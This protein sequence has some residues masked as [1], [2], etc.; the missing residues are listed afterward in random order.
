[1]DYPETT[2]P[3][4]VTR[5]AQR[6]IDLGQLAWTRKGL[7]I[8]TLLLGVAGGYFYFRSQDPIYQSQATVQIVEPFTKNLP[9]SGVDAFSDRN[10]L[11]N[12]IVVMRSEHV[13][14]HA[15]ELGSLH[16]LPQFAGMPS[17]AIAAYLSGTRDLTVTPAIA[18]NGANVFNVSFKS[19]DASGAQRIVQAVIDA[20]ARYLRDQQTNVGEETLSLIQEARGEVLSKLE[21][22]EAE[23]DKFA[24]TSA[25]VYRDGKITSIHR[26]HAESYLL[27]KQRLMIDRDKI[28]SRYDAA[29]RGFKAGVPV[30]SLLLAMGSGSD[31]ALKEVEM[32]RAN[33]ASINRTQLLAQMRQETESRAERMRETMLM[34]LELQARQFAD[35]FGSGHPSVRSIEDNIKTVTELI[36]K[37]A[38]GEEE[39]KQKWQAAIAEAEAQANSETGEA[40][41]P[42]ERLAARLKNQLYFTLQAMQ[43]ELRALEDQLQVVATAYDREIKAAQAEGTAETNLQRLQR[44]ISRQ[45]GLYDRIVA[46]LD[47]VNIMSGADGLRLVLLNS[48]KRGIQIAPS[49]SRSLIMAGMLGLMCGFALAYLLE[50]TDLSYHSAE[51]ISEHLQTPVIGQLQLAKRRKRPAELADVTFSDELHTFFHPKTSLAEG[52]RAIRTALFF[53][54]QKGDH[55][56]LQVT[57]AIPGEGKT[58]VASNLAVSIAQSGKSVLLIDADLRR[59][60][61]ET[62]MGIECEQGLAWILDEMKRTGVSTSAGVGELLGEV[63]HD[64]AVENLSVITAGDPPDDPAELLASSRMDRLMEAVRSRFDLVIIDTP[65]LLAVTDPSNVAPRVDSVLMVVRLN[66]GARPNAARAMRMLETLEA[67]VVGV[68]VNG[69]GSRHAGRYGYYDGRDGYYNGSYY[70]YGNGYSY[71]SNIGGRFSEYYDDRSSQ[72]G[73][74]I[75]KVPKQPANGKDIGLK[76]KAE[77]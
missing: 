75:K 74:K 1:M 60:R 39:L 40:P 76:V 10:T 38:A 54:N 13:L 46:R 26:E 66:K 16:E 61:V 27:Q 67:N 28:Q 53:S 31:A 71:G 7:L 47:E 37:T 18:G 64:T 43:Q 63:I 73:K 52:F 11:E 68:V 22:L 35:Q 4:P 77:S 25:L 42:Q 36:E 57:S 69:V 12:E 65:P 49:L 34:P 48:P 50:L 9:V 19:T 3:V 21:S 29:I 33:Q 41:E 44:D 59:P 72:R 32:Q 55:K 20:Y 2:P 14:T 24:R 56:I 6:Q 30:E 62:V 8:L 45:Q 51:Q 17:T 15:A 23:Y 58:T 5:P 70:K